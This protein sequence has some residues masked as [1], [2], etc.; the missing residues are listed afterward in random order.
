MDD[1]LSCAEAAGNPADVPRDAAL[2]L[3]MERIRK[4]FVASLHLNV[5]EEELPYEQMLE[6][7]AI[8]DSIAVLEFVTAVERE[9]GVSIQPEFIEFGFLRDLA[10][11]ASYIEDRIETRPVAKSRANP[12]E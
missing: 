1:H 3:I 11:L 5:S 6:E 12:G 10:G 7:A 9:F 2:L 8:L 4:V